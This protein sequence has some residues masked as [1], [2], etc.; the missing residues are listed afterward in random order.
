M[1]V[2]FPGVINIYIPMV[3]HLVLV[4]RSVSDLIEFPSE[5]HQII[6]KKE[7]TKFVTEHDEVFFP[8]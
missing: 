6:I 7:K 1:F 3:M 5:H 4:I 2:F 8:S